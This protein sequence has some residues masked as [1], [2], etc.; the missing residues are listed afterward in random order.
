M[1]L[2]IGRIVELLQFVRIAAV[3]QSGQSGAHRQTHCRGTLADTDGKIDMLVSGVGTGGTITGC[4]EVLKARNPKVEI[5]AVE[6]GG[7]AGPKRRKAWA[8]QDSGYRRGF[9]PS[10]LNRDIID[11]VL[12]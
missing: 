4:G 7:F 10:V 12:P 6:P 1:R 5:I 2:R 3:Y 11:R 8:A 9:V